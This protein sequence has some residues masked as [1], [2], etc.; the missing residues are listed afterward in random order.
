MVLASPLNSVINKSEILTRKGD[1]EDE[2]N[3]GNHQAFQV[4]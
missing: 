2:T 1:K 3:Y 4:G